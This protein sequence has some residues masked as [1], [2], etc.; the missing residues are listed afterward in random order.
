M[1]KNKE[2]QGNIEIRLVLLPGDELYT[3]FQEIKDKLGLKS[4]TEAARACIKR[5]CQALNKI[6]QSENHI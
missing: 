6:F 5:G 2:N 1:P 4:N 3:P